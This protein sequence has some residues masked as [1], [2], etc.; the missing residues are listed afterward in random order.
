M[1]SVHLAHEE[2][3]G[4]GAVVTASSRQG[5]P[6]S[7]LRGSCGFTNSSRHLS[8][9]IV[10]HPRT[11]SGRCSLPT[12]RHC[13]DVGVLRGKSGRLVSQLHR[14][15]V[16]RPNHGLQ[17]DIGPVTASSGVEVATY[18]AG[19]LAF[20]ANLPVVIEARFICGRC[21]RT[22]W[23]RSGHSTTSPIIR[24]QLHG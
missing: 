15:L 17:Y 9:G 10:H 23:V 2:V 16:S 6:E 4:L 11:C 14:T 5:N 20:K 8:S 21:I 12:R 19:I 7:L 1:L 22:H 13:N 18:K 3:N 24:Q